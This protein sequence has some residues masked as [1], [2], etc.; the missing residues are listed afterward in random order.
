MMRRKIGAS[1]IEGVSGAKK[2]WMEG[3]DE[4][5]RGAWVYQAILVPAKQQVGGEISS[6]QKRKIG[7]LVAPFLQNGG[8]RMTRPSDGARVVVVRTFS[9]N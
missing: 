9:L 2:V 1:E 7:C 5:S 8:W 6:V 4:E 3:Q